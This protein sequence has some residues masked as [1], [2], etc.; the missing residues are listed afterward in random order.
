M[1]SITHFV[2]N[3]LF[4][5]S[6]AFIV[7]KHSKNHKI[8]VVILMLSILSFLTHIASLKVTSLL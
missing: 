6:I 7:I 2:I 4:R 8:V 3:S 5:F 1:I